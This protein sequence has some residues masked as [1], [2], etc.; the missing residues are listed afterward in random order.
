MSE[1][2]GNPVGWRWAP[3]YFN[4]DQLDARNAWHLSSTEPSSGEGFVVEELYSRSVVDGLL[5][6]LEKLKRQTGR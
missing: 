4:A 1:R 6:E 5:A 3:S 2:I